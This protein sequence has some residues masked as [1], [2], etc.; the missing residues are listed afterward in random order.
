MS[1]VAAPIEFK[2]RIELI[3]TD[4]L[5]VYTYPSG[6]TSPAVSVGEPP[7]DLKVQGLESVIYLPQVIEPTQQL[8][9]NAG[10]FSK[11]LWTIMLVARPESDTEPPSTGNLYE[12][13]QILQRHFQ[14]FTSV[15]TPRNSILKTFEQYRCNIAQFSCLDFLDRPL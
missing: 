1:I 3:L 8:G 7:S 12:A 10:M 14:Q 9:G 13:H 11:I 4:Y 5:G 2:N 6:Y 15:H